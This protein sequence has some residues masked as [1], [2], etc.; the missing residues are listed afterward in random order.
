VWQADLG[1]WKVN[2]TEYEFCQILTGV[3]I[4]HSSDGSSKKLIAGDNFVIPA[5]FSGEWQVIET[6]KK[7][8]VIFEPAS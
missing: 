4:L 7:I 8:Y 1:R 2:Y 6:T 3:S 5:G